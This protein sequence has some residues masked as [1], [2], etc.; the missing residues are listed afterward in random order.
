MPRIGGVVP[1]S[2]GLSLTVRVPAASEANP[3]EA[4]DLLV[5]AGTGSYEARP[6]V[7]GEA[8]RLVAKHPVRDG[9]TPLGVYVYGYSRVDKFTYTGTAPAIGASI[10]AAGPDTVRAAAAGNGS[11]VLHVDTARGYVEVA[12]P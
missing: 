8:L 5:L 9:I 10:E 7:A 4:G 11:Y 6:A 3:I 2:Y 12:M 1:D